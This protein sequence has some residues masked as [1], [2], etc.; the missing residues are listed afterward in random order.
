MRKYILSVLTYV[1]QSMNTHAHIY[2]YFYTLRCMC[3]SIYN[4]Y[5][6]CLIFFTDSYRRQLSLKEREKKRRY[7]LVR[8]IFIF[9]SK[10]KVRPCVSVCP[11]PPP[12]PLPV[13]PSH[14]QPLSLSRQYIE[15]AN[16]LWLTRFPATI[17]R[18]ALEARRNRNYSFLMSRAKRR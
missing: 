11:P 7:L 4:I 12:A 6:A 17:E 15:E 10:C 8:R 18:N 16:Q 5:H 1:V 2:I 3:A 13:C 9:L 14:W